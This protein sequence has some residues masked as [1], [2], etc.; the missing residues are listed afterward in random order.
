M[1]NIRREVLNFAHRHVGGYCSE[2]LQIDG[3]QL[4]AAEI[5]SLLTN[6]TPDDTGVAL[7]RF[8][9]GARDSLQLARGLGWRE[10]MR[11]VLARGVRIQNHDDAPTTESSALTWFS[12]RTGPRWWA[13]RSPCRCAESDVR[14]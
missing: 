4:V 12:G 10:H 9:S 11:I 14:T 3:A 1:R 7:R 13:V 8:D 6:V 5:N 2:P